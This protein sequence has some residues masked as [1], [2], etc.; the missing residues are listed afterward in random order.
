[1]WGFR[2]VGILK[3]RF[4]SLRRLPNRIITESDL[5]WTYAWIGSCIILH[6]LLIDNAE[7]APSAEE[8]Q[9][10]VEEERLGK[11]EHAQINQEEPDA[12]RRE[13]GFG[14]TTTTRA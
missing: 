8:I 2:S 3:A 11:E 6:N 5:N 13:R 14:E 10:I 12:E 9:Q 1:M 4:S 7:S